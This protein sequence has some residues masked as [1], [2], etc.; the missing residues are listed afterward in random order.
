M[1]SFMVCRA[2]SLA[3]EAVFPDIDPLQQ[4][5]ILGRPKGDSVT[6]HLAA[7]EDVVVFLRYGIDPNHS[8]QE[9]DHLPSLVQFQH[10]DELR[11]QYRALVY[12]TAPAIIHQPPNN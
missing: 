6:A 1:V 10:G 4:G 7:E 2:V 12:S 11:I 5:I 9:T 8:D 3:Q